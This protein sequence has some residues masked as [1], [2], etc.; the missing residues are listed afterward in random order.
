MIPKTTL[1][2]R[3]LK[4]KEDALEFAMKLIGLRRQSEAEIRNRL[5]KRNCDDNCIE[6]TVAELYKFG[7]LD[8]EAF[9]ESYINDRIKLRP[10]GK[11]LIRAE[12]RKKG[13]DRGMIDKK[14]D[15]LLSAEDELASAKEILRKKLRTANSKDENKIKAKLAFHL[16]SRGFSSAVI[17]EAIQNIL[18]TDKTHT[19]E[20]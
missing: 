9:A 16:R 4:N 3:P 6:A 7:Y 11:S 19:H 10:A 13:I 8:D 2:P 12:L 15:E 14:L 18:S 17:N 1:M 20:K 5:R